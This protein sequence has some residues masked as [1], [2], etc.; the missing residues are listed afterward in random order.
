[1]AIS[2]S[3]NC[4]N[5]TYELG[6]LWSIVDTEKAFVVYSKALECYN[7]ACSLQ[8]NDPSLLET[9]YS[10]LNNLASSSKKNS[11][12]KKFKKEAKTVLERIE[13]LT[14]VKRRASRDP[15]GPE[16]EILCNPIVRIVTRRSA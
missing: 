9:L 6:N 5:A 2:I 13:K 8:P 14:G 16:D 7:L 1:M 3:I 10:V 12:K 4:A 15:K 11:E